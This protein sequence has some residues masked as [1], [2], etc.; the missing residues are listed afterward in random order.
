MYKN[1]NFRKFD[2]M[3]VSR[4]LKRYKENLK[5]KKKSNDEIPLKI[6]HVRGRPLLLDVELDLKLRSVILPLRTAEAGINQHVV[7]G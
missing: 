7:R 3:K 4:I 5:E 2:V 1:L 6:G